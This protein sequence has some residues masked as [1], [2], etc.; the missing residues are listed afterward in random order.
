M[1]NNFIELGH[2]KVTVKIFIYKKKIFEKISVS[3][4]VI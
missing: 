4:N 2:I 3:E 1:K